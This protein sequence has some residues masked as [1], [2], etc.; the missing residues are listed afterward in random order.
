[1][2]PTLAR[3]DHVIRP[4]LPRLADRVRCGG[5]PIPFRQ[6]VDVVIRGLQRPSADRLRPEQRGD[7][8]CVRLDPG[9]ERP[10]RPFA[11]LARGPSRTA[12]RARRVRRRV[13]AV[14]L[15][16]H[17]APVLPGVRPH[18]P[19]FEPG[20]VC[21]PDGQLVRPPPC[22]GG[23]RIPARLFARR[24]VRAAGA[25]PRGVRLARHG[26]LRRA[27]DPSDRATPGAGGA[28]PAH[29]Q[30]GKSPTESAHRSGPP[31]R[32]A[33]ADPISRRRRRCG[34]WAFWFLSVGHALA[35]LTVSAVMVHMPHLTADNGLAFSLAEASR[36]M[37]D[38]R[39]PDG[40][41]PAGGWLG[42]RMEKRLVCVGCMIAH[43]TGF[44][45][46]AFASNI[47]M[48]GRLRRPARTRL[49]HPGAVDGHPAGRLLRC[50][51]VRHDH[52]ALVPDRDVGHAGRT[53]RRR[54]PGGR[55]GRHASGF[56][57]LACGSLLGGVLFRRGNAA[58][59]AFAACRTMTPGANR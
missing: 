9:G 59:P 3:L 17:G 25:L 12:H 48:V 41:Q 56:A 46:L 5:N 6:P 10:A 39:L 27:G 30:G 54:L 49:G 43:G 52:G 47:G 32:M 26:S 14:R 58:A 53:R 42:D 33:A 21:N 35:L 45:F 38:D 22:H 13:R 15:H 4:C 50:N 1:M 29:C 11:G 28:A 2:N 19:R 20:R 37:A 16:R 40:R 18:R 55:H 51:F 31:S 24:S 8:R 23:R 34:T 44:L 36:V 7:R 57:M